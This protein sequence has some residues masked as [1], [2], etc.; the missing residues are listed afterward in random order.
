MPRKIRSIKERFESKLD[1]T[2]SFQGCWL[3]TA[4]KQKGYG[5]L[6]IGTHGKPKLESAHRISWMLYRGPI[7][8][9]KDVLHG[10]PVKDTPACCNPNHLHLGDQKMNAIEAESKGQFNHPLGKDNGKSKLS[11]EQ[12]DFIRQTYRRGA[13]GCRMIA[14]QLGN[15]THQAVYDVIMGRTWSHHKSPVDNPS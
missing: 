8:E 3:W 1:K 4:A 15:V 14:E 10:C 11:P 13:V 7:P 6:Q 2:S 12:V 9:G 5:C